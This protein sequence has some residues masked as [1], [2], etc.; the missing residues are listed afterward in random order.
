MLFRSGP[1]T[2]LERR[3]CDRFGVRRPFDILT[4][5]RSGRIGELAAVDAA[6]VVFEAARD[7]DAVARGIVDHLADELVLLGVSAIRRLGLTRSPVEV[8]LI[9]SV[10]KTD[11][12]AFHARVRDGLLTVAPGA[13]IERLHEPPVLGAALIGLD[14]LGAG[15]PAHALARRT[16]GAATFP[17]A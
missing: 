1:R 3:L 9:G 6:P 15:E 5:L 8:V 14:L 12:A 10:W 16:I 2:V 4:H 7:G 11:D 13:R 17:V